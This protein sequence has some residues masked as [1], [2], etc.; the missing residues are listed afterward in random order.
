MTLN[1]GRAG[2]EWNSGCPIPPGHW[3]IA[4]RKGDQ[5]GLIGT[6]G[7]HAPSCQCRALAPCLGTMTHAPAHDA[8][9]APLARL[10]ARHPGIEGQVLWASESAEGWQV[11]DDAAELLDA[12]EIPFYVEGLL[13]EGFG[14]VW[15]VMAEATAGK[16]EPDHVLVM[17]W[18]PGTTPPPAP[19]AAEGWTVIASGRWDGTPATS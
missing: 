8:F 13:M 3:H 5:S 14:L 16:P 19:E 2:W 12:E 11:Q 10:A 18:E 4:G 6:R 7:R 1:M 9:L 17:V 15:Q